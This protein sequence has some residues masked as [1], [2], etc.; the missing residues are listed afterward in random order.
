VPLSGMVFLF[1]F[2]K[3]IEKLKG[4]RNE[5]SKVFTGIKT[6]KERA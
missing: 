4:K 1:P 6:I 5:M 3:E 2:A